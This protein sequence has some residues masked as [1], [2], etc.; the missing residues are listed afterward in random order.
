MP[1]FLAEPDVLDRAISRSRRR[2]IP[3][4][5]LMYVLSYLDR[6]NIGYAKQA[7]QAA[8]G[9][10]DA[11]FALGAGV[12][13]LTYALFEIP[14]NLVLHRVGARI[15]LARIMVVWGLISAATVFA[16]TDFSFSAVR[17]L[18]GAAEAGFFPG[19]I[20]YLTYWFPAR[21]RGQMMALF[22]FGSP[23]AL[24]LGGPLSGALLEMNGVFGLA[25]W[26][27]MFATEGL[28]AA[29]V[30][31]WAFFFLTDRPAKALWMPAAEREALSKAIAAEERTKQERGAVTFG[32]VFRNPRLL[33]FAAIYFLIQVSGYGVAF[34]LPTQVGALL[35][36][37]VGL[38]VGVIS[39][40][41]WACAILVTSF[42]PGLAARTGY[43]RTF[44]IISLAGIALGLALAVNLPPAPAI[45]AMCLVTAGIISAQP[46]FWTFPT[47]Y[48]GGIGAAAGIATINALGNLGGFVAPSVKTWL[49]HRFSSSII[50][51]YFLAFTAI[52]AALLVARLPLFEET[53]LNLRATSD[54]EE[55]LAAGRSEQG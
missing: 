20:L 53:M 17:V 24:M 44:A 13:F 22:Y 42:W 4:L 49:E 5:L 34:Y 27:L 38:W 43:R 23:L 8:T 37:K 3:F 26:Q 47:A 39:A 45:A 35:G 10:S 29:I 52:A 14:S 40:I 55:P 36:V 48:F 32:A 28:L 54:A 31:V 7:Y 2:L 46:I 16:K 12:F 21:A 1:Q 18:L 9:I 19:S 6:A 30:G 51:L 25:G 50:G 41:P 15:W 11:A 33:H